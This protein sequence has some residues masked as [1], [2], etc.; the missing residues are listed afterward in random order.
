MTFRLFY[1]D[2]LPIPKTCLPIEINQIIIWKCC[3]QNAGILQVYIKDLIIELI[4]LLI[5]KVAFTRYAEAYTLVTMAIDLIKM[6]PMLYVETDSVIKHRIWLWL[7]F[8]LHP[9]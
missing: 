6:V 8:V 2:P 7:N 1:A 5:L 3:Q 4:K 9:I